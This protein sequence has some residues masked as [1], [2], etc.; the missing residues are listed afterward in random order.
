[1][2]FGGALFCVIGVDRQPQ[3]SFT[4]GLLSPSLSRSDMVPIRLWL[5]CV[6]LI[7]FTSIA[8]FNDK[9]HGVICNAFSM[10]SKVHMRRH[11]DVN[12]GRASSSSVLRMGLTAGDIPSLSVKEAINAVCGPV[13][14]IPPKYL[15]PNTD[16][17][18]SV[19]TPCRF[20][21][22]NPKAFMEQPRIA[23]MY[24]FDIDEIGGPSIPVEK[25]VYHLPVIYIADVHPEYGT[26][27]FVLNKKTGLTMND[28][29]P[30]LKSLRRAQV[31][32]GGSQNKG[33]SFTMVH[34]KA[35]FPDNRPWKGIPGNTEFK[36]F[37]SPNIAMANELCLTKDA[38]PGDFKFFQWGAVW[39]PNQLTLEYQ[40][41]MWL[42]VQAPVSLLFQDDVDE[43]PLWRRVV[44]SLPEGLLRGGGTG[45]SASARLPVSA[46]GGD[47]DGSDNM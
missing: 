11:T 5:I 18:K 41:K 24:G 15:I 30:E 35:G 43:V 9:N 31:Y 16:V 20:I 2:H 27:G 32:Q 10:F 44:A 23:K 33:S 26:L 45:S 34:N 14:D 12:R 4:V 37:F 36:L 40:R 28:L 39:L 22:A 17:V 1:M 21:I 6:W 25:L 38:T 13:E 8:S 46:S 3:I 47:D 19:P 29:N 7:V 42:T